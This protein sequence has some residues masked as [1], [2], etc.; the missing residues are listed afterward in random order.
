MKYL[1]IVNGHVIYP[2]ELI[3]LKEDYPNTSFPENFNQLVFDDYDIYLVNLIDISNDY[4]KNYT[5]S[6]PILVDGEYYQNWVVSDAS[7]EEIEQRINGQW[8]VIRRQRNEY[9][10]ECD[11]TQLP[12]SPLSEQKKSEWS[13]Y[14]QELRDITSQLDPFNI[15]WPTKPQ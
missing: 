12:D 3:K 1:R 8:L 6:T 9:L 13:I 14:R 2:Y 11:W 4:T 5:E 7:S 10:S 15:V